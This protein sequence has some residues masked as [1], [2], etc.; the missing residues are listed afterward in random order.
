MADF[1]HLNALEFRLHNE[2][3][4]LSQ[5]KTS[6]ERAARTAIVA[7]IERE[8]VWERDFLGMNGYTQLPFA[9][10]DDLLAALQA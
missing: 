5:S 1:S 8:I 4:R 6:A 7:G 9:S 2:R 10:D 3:Q